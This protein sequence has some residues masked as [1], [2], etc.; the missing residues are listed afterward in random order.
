M[1]GDGGEGDVVAREQAARRQQR[2]ALA[3]VLAGGADVRPG[4][5][6]P[7]DQ[8][9]VGALGGDLDLRDGVEAIVDR[10]PRVDPQVRRPARSTPLATSAAT[11]AYPSIAAQRCGGLAASAISGAPSTRPQAA[12]SG[13]R[14]A[15]SG[16]CHPASASAPSQAS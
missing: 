9:A 3:H 2:V 8:Q 14:S 16:A 4:L 5:D 13:T 10:L 6:G 11:T 7:L 12:S 15:A 1:A